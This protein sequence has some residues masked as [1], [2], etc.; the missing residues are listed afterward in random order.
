M[1][2]NHSYLTSENVSIFSNKF[3][4]FKQKIASSWAFKTAQL[5]ILEIC[6][7]YQKFFFNYFTFEK[8]T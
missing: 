3:I 2:L 8:H 5:G 7:H 4:E 6:G 1:L